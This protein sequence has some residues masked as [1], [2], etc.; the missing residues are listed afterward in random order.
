LAK[1]KLTP[2]VVVVL[3]AA[4]LSAGLAW[5]GGGRARLA[6]GPR[7]PIG[8]AAV[9]GTLAVAVRQADIA[10]EILDQRWAY[11]PSDADGNP[12]GGLLALDN[13][14]GDVSNLCTAAPA[15]PILGS[16]DIGSWVAHGA[17]GG[18][19][20]IIVLRAHT[21]SVSI[22]G[23]VHPTFA[24]IGATGQPPAGTSVFSEL[25]SFSTFGPGDCTGTAF[26]F[27]PDTA[28]RKSFTVGLV[29][30]SNAPPLITVT[31]TATATAPSSRKPPRCKKGQKPT[32]KN[33]CRK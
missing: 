13:R 33:P 24:V 19:A 25:R 30:A 22:P 23:N 4:G 12:V 29:Y 3:L 20:V 26:A 6:V 11:A 9:G 7:L 18:S 15:Q 8:V 27:H 1:P 14:M 2:V 28:G 32:K 21:G 17:G 31:V 10:V 5:G 16:V